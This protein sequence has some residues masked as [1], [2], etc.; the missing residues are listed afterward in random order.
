MYALGEKQLSSI[1]SFSD[2]DSAGADGEVGSISKYSSASQLEAVVV[3]QDHPGG[4][5]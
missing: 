4:G 3:A 2:F 1:E 5:A